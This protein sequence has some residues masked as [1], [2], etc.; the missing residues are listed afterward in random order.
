MG[1]GAHAVLHMKTYVATDA[2]DRPPHRHLFPRQTRAS[3]RPSAGVRPGAAVNYDPGFPSTPQNQNRMTDSTTTGWYYALQG[4][5]VGPRS[6]DEVRSLVANGVLD[7]DSLVWTPGMRDWS[8]VGE[9]SILAPGWVQPHS[10]PAPRAEAE[11]AP[12]AD[13]S[14]QRAVVAQQPR[15]WRRFG[16]RL[17]DVVIFMAIA[18]SVAMMIIP[19]LR[20]RMP[21]DPASVKPLYNLLAVLSLVP[22]EG[23]VLHLFGTTPG[24]ALFG[25]QVSTAEGDRPSLRQ[26][27]S[28]AVRV[29]VLGMGMGLPIVSLCAMVAGYVRLTS[30]GHTVWDEALGLQV[31]YAEITPG[32]AMGIVGLF[33]FFLFVLGS[34]MSGVAPAP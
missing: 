28:R 15:P 32:R 29:W 3:A 20:A 30:R 13:V 9:V 18:A 33:L 16:A 5:R 6:L 25:I 7:A 19:G 34:S 1:G 21:A 14:Q 12:G 17:L 4:E 10:A 31:E 11:W 23:L 8:R 24:K 22:I 27:F 2:T 26:S